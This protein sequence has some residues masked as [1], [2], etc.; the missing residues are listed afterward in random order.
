MPFDAS[1]K[2]MSVISRRTSDSVRVVFGKGAVE[3]V[4]DRCTHIVAAD[5][6]VIEIS[7]SLRADVISQSERYADEALRVLAFAFREDISAA[8]ASQSLDLAN[9][10]AIECNW[11]FAGLAGLQDPPRPESEPAVR[12]CHRAG[13]A[14]R[15]ATGDHPRTAAAIARSVGIIA[16]D[17][18]VGVITA[19]EFDAMT[20]EE[21]DA[22]PELPLVIARCAPS[23]KV[24]LIEAL[25]RRKRIVA[26]TGDGVNDAPA[27]KRADIGIAMGL[28]GTD[29][30]KQA[31]DVVLTDDNFATIVAAIAEGRRLVANI[32]KF[33]MHLLTGNVS[34]VVMLVIGLGLVGV[35]GDIVFPMSPLQILWMNLVTLSI[36]TIF[37]GLEKSTTDVLNQPPR[38]TR[39]V[40][41]GK[42][43]MIDTLV[44]GLVS[45]LVALAVFAIVVAA[46][47]TGSFG[48]IG[49]NHSDTLPGCSAVYRARAASFVTH[50]FVLLIHA[51]NC[52]DL[53]ESMFKLSP[54]GNKPLLIAIS[55][56]AVIVVPLVYIPYV[57]VQLFRQAPIGWEWGLVVGGVVFFVVIAELYKMYKRSEKGQCKGNGLSRLWSK[58][59]F[60]DD[61]SKASSSAIELV[62]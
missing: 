21:V 35:P 58:S 38:S 62:V 45:G 13:I 40:V 11:T 50:C 42:E 41:F 53:R 29:V 10:D 22:M 18:T 47:P 52:R 59:T 4:L 31:A 5:G 55:I 15:M 17:S 61:D 28:G 46:D 20:D 8:D 51:Y 12:R 49:C 30:T 7:D 54:A 24:K 27:V 60:G 23:S 57:N 36:P 2:R 9:R 56:N 16:P 25:H 1:L 39:S 14:V 26:M 43:V 19:Q 48:A 6:S 32:A 44:Y 37:L 3:I 34:Q 33:T